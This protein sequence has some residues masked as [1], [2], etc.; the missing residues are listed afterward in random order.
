MQRS[1][2]LCTCAY[3][4]VIYFRP[5]AHKGALASASTSACSSRYVHELAHAPTPPCTCPY[6]YPC[7]CARICIR[8]NAQAAK[9]M[10][11]HRHMDMRTHIGINTR[12]Q[13]HAHVNA[14]TPAHA[15]AIDRMGAH[16]QGCAGGC[17]R[18]CAPPCT[19]PCVHDSRSVSHTCAPLRCE[20][21]HERTHVLIRHDMTRMETRIAMHMIRAQA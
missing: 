18:P 8:T 1:A 12:R 13:T 2:C 4:S 16:A 19:P 9:H 17:A 14:H 20:H 21:T 6:T 15:L 3:A 5:L 7:Q 10:H 11:R